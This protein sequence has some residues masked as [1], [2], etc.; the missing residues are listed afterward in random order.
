[1]VAVALMTEAR[2]R[3]Q[4]AL[5][6]AARRDGLHPRRRGLGRARTRRRAAAS[7]PLPPAALAAVALAGRDPVR[8]RRRRAARQG[9]ATGWRG[10]RD[11]YGADLKAVD[12]QGGRRAGPEGLRARL[13]RRVPDPGGRVVPAPA[14]DRGVGS[15]RCRR[16]RSIA[17]P[18]TRPSRDDPRFPK[19][20]ETTRWM[21]GRSCPAAADHG[22]TLTPMATIAPRRPAG[23]PASV[24]GSAPVAR[25]ARGSGPGRCSS[26]LLRTRDLD[27]GFW[28]DEGLSVGI[29]DRPLSDI[30][31]GAAPR[32][33]AA[34][35]LRAAA[36][37]DERVREH[38]GRP[39]TRS[40]CCSRVLAVPAAWWAARG[41]FG[42]TAGLDR[43]RC[44]PRRTRS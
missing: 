27:V 35:V 25:A 5:R 1:M 29:A 2:L 23:L 11:L 20:A 43:R 37:V 19:V 34:A 9:D 17:P 22:T 36:P 33:L 40:R 8:G 3:R 41:L 7:R 26:V 42:P 44:W 32:R 30:P 13:H 4:P 14:R 28:I 16:A 18:T 39:P 10:R 6:R 31:G 15:S 38:R 24:A 21:V 12:R